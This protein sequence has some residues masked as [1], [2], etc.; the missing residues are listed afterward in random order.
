MPDLSLSAL[1]SLLRPFVTRVFRHAPRLLA[2]RRAGQVPMTQPSSLM[3]DL[4]NE[5]LDRI[6]GG[7]ID[8]GWWQSLLDQFGQQYI[9]PDFL[10]KPSIQEWLAETPV[11]NDLKAIATWRVM[12][13]AEDEG[14]TPRP[15]RAKLLEPHRRGSVFCCGTRRCRGRP[16]SSRGISERFVPINVQS[17]GWCKLDIRAPTIASTA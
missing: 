15:P 7:S 8:T 9:A 6:R 2:E 16:S 5:T 1:A 14:R 4:L 10:T 17:Q 13:T 11:A 12:A 3:D